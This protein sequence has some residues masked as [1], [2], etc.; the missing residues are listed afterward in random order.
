M[1]LAKDTRETLGLAIEA[2]IY[3]LVA[4]GPDPEA[5][6]SLGATTALAV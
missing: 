4:I 3:L 5:E 2:L 1:R 6:P